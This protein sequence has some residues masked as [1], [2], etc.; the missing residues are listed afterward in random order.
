[1]LSFGSVDA[2]VEADPSV[3][4]PSVGLGNSGELAP[5]IVSIGDTVSFQMGQATAIAKERARHR[6]HDLSAETQNVSGD[7][8]GKGCGVAVDGGSWGGQCGWWQ[9][10][11]SV[12]APTVR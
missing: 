3:V 7:G 2:G 11:W 12:M 8:R 9:L 10:G 4:R 5:G 6:L 1:M